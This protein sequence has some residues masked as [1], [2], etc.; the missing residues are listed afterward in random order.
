M[1]ATRDGRRMTRSPCRLGKGSRVSR[2]S[3]VI[4]LD[5]LR[6]QGFS[7][8]DHGP[9]H[10]ALDRTWADPH[11]IGGLRLGQAGVVAQHY[12]LTLPLGE[13]AEGGHDGVALQQGKRTVFGARH[14]RRVLLQVLVDDYLMT[15][16]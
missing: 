16:D 7:Q 8:A 12:R 2:S 11:G 13:L 5:Q 3:I 6:L 10:V 14:V 15:N 9:R 4:R 1:S